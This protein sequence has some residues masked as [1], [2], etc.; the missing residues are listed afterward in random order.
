MNVKTMLV[1]KP[2]RSTIE[3]TPM[4]NKS[5]KTQKI[6]PEEIKKAMKK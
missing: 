6:V 2:S 1:N 3:W 4:E 5:E